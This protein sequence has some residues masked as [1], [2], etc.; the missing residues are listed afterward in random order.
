MPEDAADFAWGE[1]D[2][3]SLFITASKE[4]PGLSFGPYPSSP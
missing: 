3:R 1:S 2:R 4:K